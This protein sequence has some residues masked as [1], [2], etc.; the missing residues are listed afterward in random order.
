[1][2]N[3]NF[4]IRLRQTRHASVLVLTLIVVAMLTLGA[5][6]FFERMFAEHQAERA[7]GQQLQAS[8]LAESGI[9][10][11]KVMTTKTSD[12]IQQ[13]GGFYS[14]PSL[15]QGIVVNDDPMAAFRGR[16]T[17]LAPDMT[18]D[19]YYG[20]IR[21]GLENESARLNLNTILLA[22]NTQPGTA[23]KILMSLPGM[24]ESIADAILDWIDPDDQQRDNGAERD[25]YASLD[26]PYVPRNGPIASIEE[27][28]LVRGV[29]P[30]L[31]FG[32]D[33]NR[34][35]AID[36]NE[37]K[38]T[39]IDN[40]DNSNGV[41]N[42]GWAAYLTVD[43]AEANVRP[44]GKPKID[45][46]MDNLQ[47]L[48]TQ[49][50]EVL[51][52][53]QADFIVAY[54]QGGPYTGSDSGKP[55]SD[56][57]IDLTQKGNEKLSTILDLIGAR[58]RIAKQ[59]SSGSSGGGGGGGTLSIG[60]TGGGSGSGSGGGNGG[61]GRSK[62]LSTPS[63]GGESQGHASSGGG[64]SGGS[65]DSR[66]VI[67]PA[68]P[69]DKSAMATYLPKLM[70]NLAVNAAPSI[71]GR[72]NINQAPCALLAGIPGLT[73]D[74][75]DQIISQRDVTMGT[76]RPEQ[77]Y[78]TWLLTSDVVDLPTM[79]QLIPLV[80]GGGNVYRAQVVGGFFVP[81][82]PVYRLEVL[83]DATKSPAIV[84]RRWDL[85]DLGRGFTPE[86]LGAEADDAK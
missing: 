25:Y 65:N 67:E 6:A 9:E 47:E 3:N 23:Q 29:T 20:G 31:L 86:V 66:V 18:S 85:T 71:P 54:R 35:G 38:L 33:L 34:N 30:A 22:D 11:M 1:M 39:D 75:V 79:K 83:I 26:P 53:D 8:Q 32:A 43:S 58:T 50:L 51:D 10:Y 62:T 82:G 77:K 16:F 48:S 27:L 72:L 2:M 76:Q 14:N 41:L 13:L 57:T 28:L 24:T 5:A 70:D 59:G 36:G 17:L 4:R 81:D 69:N 49:L 68:F 40:T 12:E 78:E 45:V 84:R 19:G 42:R 46:N 55:V 56:Q 74:K 61:G 64:T 60:G 73:P 21:Y 15:F 37:Q 80:T 52:K 7:H 44:D 63:G